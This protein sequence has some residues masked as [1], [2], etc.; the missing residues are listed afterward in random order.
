MALAGPLGWLSFGG[1]ITQTGAGIRAARQEAALY[2]FNAHMSRLAAKDAKRRGEIAVD[3]LRME[4]SQLVGEQKLAFGAGNVMLDSGSA[5]EVVQ[6]TKRVAEMD[7]AMIRNNAAR[8]AWGY[9][10]EAALA[11]AQSETVK[12]GMLPKALG[13]LA[14]GGAQSY[15]LYKSLET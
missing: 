8:E 2:D 1:S 13:T 7:V 9:R 14:T 4:V 12:S 5:L 6:D 15:S 3:Q 11:R 10:V